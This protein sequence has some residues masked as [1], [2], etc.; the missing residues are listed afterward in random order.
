MITWIKQNNFFWS[1]LLW[2]SLEQVNSGWGTFA[3]SFV[4]VLNNQM[5]IIGFCRLQ[6]T[7]QTVHIWFTMPN[8]FNGTTPSHILKFFILFIALSTCTLKEAILWVLMT[9]CALI[10]TCEPRK[11]GMF[12]P[13]PGGSRSSIVKP[14]SAITESPLL[15]CWYK[16]PLLITISLSDIC[17]VYNWLTKENAPPGVIPTRHLSVAWFL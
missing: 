8:R 16:N 1:W 7:A 17:P 11:G 12:N 10:W 9:S 6:R 4:N 2:C 15:N 13:T 5:L 3:K 14:L